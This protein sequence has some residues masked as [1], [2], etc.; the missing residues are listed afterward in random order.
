MK[1]VL[2]DLFAGVGGMSLGASRAGFTVGAA[3][4]WDPIAIKSHAVNFPGA[5]HFQ[6]DVASLAGA[7]IISAIDGVPLAGLV[8]GPPC[9]G[10]SNIGKRV[11]DDPRNS[12]FGHFFRLVKETMPA[13]FV[14]ENV[15]GILNERNRDVV[16]QALRIVP[17]N[18]K[19]L[20]PKV[21]SA[22]DFGVPTSRKRVFFIGF[23]TE[24][25]AEISEEDLFAPLDYQVTVGD[26]LVGL[27]AIRSNWQTADQGWRA[28]TYGQVETSFFSRLKGHVPD[29]VGDAKAL[30]EIA[31][32]RISGNLG[33]V[34]DPVVVSR[35]RAVRPGATDPVSR[36]PRLAA[37]GYCPTLRAGTNSDRG[38]FQAV[39]PIHFS[40]ARVISPREAA[41]LQ[42]FPDW[43]QF[44]ETKWH[45]F[46]QIGN[47][48]SPGVA[49][50]LLSRLK[51]KML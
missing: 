34:H 6:T 11:V 14:A 25:M 29:N 20:A 46:R 18:Y 27:P 41:R 22:S 40:A 9:Q 3:Y 33:T 7:D 8:G 24:R 19:M 28:V 2:V 31:R 36:A 37:D 43:F 49:E 32:R 15:P 23:D 35:F 42:G 13:F 44:H 51:G 38:S 16:A 12:L 21:L 47:S 45:S 50:A 4:E 5:K 17:L 48:V 10:F 1:P 39:R 30:A 26:A